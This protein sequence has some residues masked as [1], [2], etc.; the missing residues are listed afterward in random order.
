MSAEM[1]EPCQHFCQP[2]EAFPPEL[3]AVALDDPIAAKWP[4]WLGGKWRCAL[5]SLAVG[6][7]SGEGPIH[8][9]GCGR[10][11]PKLRD[12]RRRWAAPPGRIGSTRHARNMGHRCMGEIRGSHV[13]RCIH[14]PRDVFLPCRR[15]PMVEGAGAATWRAERCFAGSPVPLQAPIA[16]IAGMEALRFSFREPPVKLRG[17]RVQARP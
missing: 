4:Q 8:R 12:N 17:S 15:A 1:A 2:R 6:C 13:H 7:F 16:K 10:R 14:R 3:S 5:A 11:S 9:T